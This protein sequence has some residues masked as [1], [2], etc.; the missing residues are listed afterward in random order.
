MENRIEIYQVSRSLDWDV[1]DEQQKKHFAWRTLGEWIAS[2]N[3]KVAGT[4]FEI[5]AE[6]NIGRLLQGLQAE[7]Q[8]WK[9][10]RYRQVRKVLDD[11]IEFWIEEKWVY[12]QS[13][14]NGRPRK[15]EHSR[16][17]ESKAMKYQDLPFVV[18]DGEEGVFFKSVKWSE[19]ILGTCVPQTWIRLVVV[20][21]NVFK[22]VLRKT[23]IQF[24]TGKTKEEIS[25]CLDLPKAFVNEMCRWLVRE[26]GWKVVATNRGGKRRREMRITYL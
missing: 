12:V 19:H 18:L 24:W 13:T 10:E 14:R 16:E 21:E 17:R 4:Y 23:G 7:D 9:V 2:D 11:V 5:Y 6:T 1:W 8:F 25:E 3:F 20:K 26:E 15:V 22:E